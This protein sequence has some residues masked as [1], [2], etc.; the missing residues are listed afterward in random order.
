MTILALLIALAIERVTV[1]LPQ[2]QGQ[3]YAKHYL[4]WVT[5]KA[6]LSEDSTSVAWFV[7]AFLP[8]LCCAVL[9]SLLPGLLEFVVQTLI[10][11]VCLGCQAIRD[12]YK[13]FLQAANRGDVEAC[14]LYSTQMGHCDSQTDKGATFGLRLVWLNY[15][16]YAAVILFFV[17]FGAPGAIFYVL[18]R[19]AFDYAC[20]EESF[21]VTSASAVRHLADFI[22]V[23]L[24]AFGLLLVGNFAH[25][26]PVWL[27][28]LFAFSERP[29]KTLT[30]V[31]SSAEVLPNPEQKD[32]DQATEPA[33]LVK[34]AK[35]NL[36]FL[37]VVVS[38]LTVVGVV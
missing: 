8:A 30:R 19:E 15:Q 14:Y 26:M 6:W 21:S 36:L 11:F 38:I 20:N 12:T 18:A 16:H 1:K 2:W 27:Q 4:D 22:P 34:L 32:V 31:A 17:A 10:L 7:V 25:A 9:M 23:R 13:C 28:S 29:S 37:L 24:S 3:T 35:R 5:E 33:M